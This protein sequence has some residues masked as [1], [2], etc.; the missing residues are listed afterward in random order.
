MS[1]TPPFPDWLPD[2]VR[3]EAERLWK[4]LPTEDDPA[5]ARSLLGRLIADPRMKGVWRVIYTRSG[6][7]VEGSNP[8]KY[9]A[10]V[11]N[12]PIA[13]RLRRKANELREQAFNHR[14]IKALE[15]E[16]ALTEKIEDATRE[17]K[18]SDQDR[19]AQLLLVHVYRDALLLR[20]IFRS[21]FEEKFRV[22]RKIA[23]DLRRNGKL[24]RAFTLELDATKLDEIADNCDIE[25]RLSDP[26]EFEDDPGIMKRESGDV[27]LRTFVASISFRTRL[28][29]DNDLYGTLANIASVV[30]QTE[31]D[32]ER[33]WEMLRS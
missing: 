11:S 17:L 20:P 6:G 27:K 10:S 7:S 31:I 25:A 4:Q 23:V 12:A 33:I 19:A 21:E 1:T 14:Q 26:I 16:A 29:F 5:K 18:W 3:Q 8:Y 24:L 30:F 9:P 32:R 13:A 2:A 22:L 28:L 15:F